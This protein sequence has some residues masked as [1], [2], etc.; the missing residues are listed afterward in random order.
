MG[1]KYP[2]DLE[3]W[4]RWQAGRDPV[5]QLKATARR[6]LRRGDEEP[7]LL[8]SSG[9]QPKV[10][11]VVESRSPTTVDALLRPIAWLA[12]ESVAV[13]APV[14]V[15]DL[16]PPAAWQEES[17]SDLTAA[18]SV[19][20]VQVVL[21]AGHYLPLGAR[22]ERWARAHGARRLVVQHGLL[23]PY[24]PPLP[25]EA[26]LLAWSAADA[27]YWASGRDDLDSHTVGSQLL[28]RA[29]SEPQ[30]PTIGDRALYLGQLHGAE[31]PRRG[32]ARAAQSFCRMT[33]AR[34]RPHPSER[35]R[36]SRLHHTRWERSGITIDRSGEPLARVNDPVVSAFSTGVIEAAARG[37]PSWVYYPDPPRWLE[38]FWDRYGMSRW[39]GE[40]TAAPDLPDQEPA[41]AIAAAI[42]GLLA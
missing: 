27:E 18:R 24:A 35:D 3:A 21:S 8:A 20:Q 23:T 28:W 41:Q 40:P 14:S 6:L 13:L 11:V 7:A 36:V 9:S 39:G 19:G 34:Y 29:A 4:Q 30:A 33:G 22:A 32:L 5:R 15:I 10:L 17:C 16:L 25:G 42:T 1:V 2:S 38:E 26:T 37:V 12:P 31:L